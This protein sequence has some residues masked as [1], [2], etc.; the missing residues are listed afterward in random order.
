MINRP[1]I[2]PLLTEFASAN[3]ALSYKIRQESRRTNVRRIR[4]VQCWTCERRQCPSN[5][6]WRPNNI[7]LEFRDE[8]TTG[9]K[10]ISLLTMKAIHH[11][12]KLATCKVL[13]HFVSTTPVVEKCDDPGCFSRLV[14]VPKQEPG[15][16]KESPPISYRVTIDVADQ[17][18]F[19]TSS[20]KYATSRNWR[21]QK[22]KCF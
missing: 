14:I 19:E 18:L 13:E 17:T 7:T 10:P 9:N 2:W 16:T 20:I 11:H 21:D 8:F 15:S 4:L 1:W 5:K 22:A 6:E 12:G 3:I